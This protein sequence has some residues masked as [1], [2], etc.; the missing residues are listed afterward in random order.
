[1]T[2]TLAPED[3]AFRAEVRQFLKDRLPAHL[4][5]KVRLLSLIHI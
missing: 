5:D 4:A 2:M 1:M 3:E